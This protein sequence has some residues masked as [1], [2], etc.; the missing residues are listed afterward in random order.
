MENGQAK[1]KVKRLMASMDVFRKLAV[2]L[3]NN[4]GK[5]A[6]TAV[7][8]IMAGRWFLVETQS[9]P[10]MAP[11]AQAPPPQHSFAHTPYVNPRAIDDL[12]GRLSDSGPIVVAINLAE[13]NKSNRYHG[14]IEII[15]PNP[16]ETLATPWIYSSNQTGYRYLG[17]AP[18]GTVA[19]HTRK[20]GGSV[21]AIVLNHIIFV[22]IEQGHGMTYVPSGNPAALQPDSEPW[23]VLKLIGQA[24]LGNRW[25]GSIEATPS[26]I[27]ARG[28]TVGERCEDG[29]ASMEDALHVHF[30]RGNVED[31]QRYPARTDPQPLVIPFPPTAST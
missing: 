30:P 2:W 12:L 14:D 24:G 1:A 28:R 23:E 7:I 8:T 20:G 17:T 27:I 9:P 16:T 13:G 6:I 19:L 4:I 21:G 22:R 25:E 10:P 18:D 15:P 29:G 3:A 31:C 11:P 26:S 5:A